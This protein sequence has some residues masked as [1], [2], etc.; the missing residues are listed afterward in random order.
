MSGRWEGEQRGDV[1]LLLTSKYN[2]PRALRWGCSSPLPLP[3][4]GRALGEGRGVGCRRPSHLPFPK[5]GV[6][7]RA[8]RPAEHAWSAVGAGGACMT[9]ACCI[10]ALP[11]WGGGEQKDGRVLGPTTQRPGV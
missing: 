10:R 3:G 8:L 5:S 4:A 7:G 9:P 6:S 1:S 11:V 2:P